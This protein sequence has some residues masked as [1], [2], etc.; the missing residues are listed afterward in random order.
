MRD[1]PQS[2]A[3]RLQKVTVFLTWN[4][5]NSLCTPNNSCLPFAVMNNILNRLA[6]T[7]VLAT[8]TLTPATTSAAPGK[9]TEKAAEGKPLKEQ[10]VGYWAPDADA[11]VKEVMKT[12]PEGADAQAALPFIKAML[13]TMVVQI[14]EGKLTMSVGGQEQNS[15][16][17]ITKE[18]K[19][20]GKLTLSVKEGDD[21]AEEATATI[22]KDKLSL[23]K[24]GEPT[25]VLNR[26]KKDEF[27][28]RKA[29]KPAFPGLE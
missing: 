14:E 23:S 6:T 21:D 25:I 29:A 24:E 17:K 10:L 28:K 22:T 18:D 9:K 7:V 5:V 1:R 20:T 19:E 16:F 12:L 2:D 13:A 3:A 8:L 15:T 27:E 4:P 26:I 11:T